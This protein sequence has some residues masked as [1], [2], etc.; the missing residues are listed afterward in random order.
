MFKIGDKIVYPRQGVGFIK[1][2]AEKDFSG[3]KKS[4]YT[5]NMYNDDMEVMIPVDKIE[6]STIRLISDEE[7]IKDTL[8]LLN[9]GVEE[10]SIDLDTKLRV[11]VNTNKINSGSIIQNAEVVSDL[12]KINKEKALNASEKQMLQNAKKNLIH[13]IVNVKGI[14]ESEAEELINSNIEC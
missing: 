1:D 7:D 3:E 9:N 2:I 10:S 5:I 13:E 12:S 4:Y 8:T 6:N 14:S 11:K